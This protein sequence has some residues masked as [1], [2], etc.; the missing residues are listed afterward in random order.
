MWIYTIRADVHYISVPRLLQRVANEGWA[1]RSGY[2]AEHARTIERLLHSTVISNEQEVI[3]HYVDPMNI[4]DAVPTWFDG[5]D[6]VEGARVVNPAYVPMATTASD[7][8]ADLQAFVPAATIRTGLDAE[9][10][11]ASSCAMTCDGA[12]SASAFSVQGGARPAQC[13][14]PDQWSPMLRDII[15]SSTLPRVPAGA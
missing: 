13:T 15:L 3:V 7:W 6:L 2:T 10:D 5:D 12:S 11:D 14:A 1:G 9:S 8:V 4:V